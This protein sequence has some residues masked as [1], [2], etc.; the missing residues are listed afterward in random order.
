MKIRTT[1]RKE[2]VSNMPDLTEVCATSE[3]K[4]KT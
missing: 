4:H 2:F 1:L 3:L